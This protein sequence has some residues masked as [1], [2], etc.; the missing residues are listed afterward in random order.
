ML[1]YK[2]FR[3]SE[4]DALSRDGETAGAP[5]DLSDGFIHF[6]TAD[7]VTETAARHFAQEDD[8]VLAA[9]HAAP[10]GQ[11]LKWETS[12]DGALFPHLYRNLFSR[13]IAWHSD[14]RLVD[15]VHDFPALKVA[16]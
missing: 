9:V 5:V 11:D 10:L 15:G 1:I 7:Q 6:S 14:L 16:V 8:L 2:I 3:Q 12:R 4:W 13:D